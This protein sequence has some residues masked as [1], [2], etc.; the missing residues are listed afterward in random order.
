[1]LLSSFIQSFVNLITKVLLRD[2]PEIGTTTANFFRGLI[3]IIISLIYF[4]FRDIDIIHDLK[5]NYNKTKLLFFRCFFGASSHIF[6]YES[7]KYMRISSSA[8][9]FSTYPIVASLIS[10]LYL[11]AKIS[12]FQIFTYVA[13]FFSVILIAKPAFIFPT[14]DKVEDTPFGIFLALISAILNGIG[15]LINKQIAFDFDVSLSTFGYGF[16]F[17]LDSMILG[18]S[19][20]NFLSG[21]NIFDYSFF[22]IFLL[23]IFY[24]YSLIYFVLAL[25]IGDPI[26]S[27][28]F[29]YFGIVLNILYNFF[30]FGG[31]ID[32]LDILGSGT[33]ITV[34]ILNNIMQ[35]K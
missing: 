11:R 7:N 27:L 12:S 2:Y 6:L 15:T 20:G 32:F 34:N 30:L 22:L 4:R 23:S 16:L 18:I 5:K 24:F 13:C 21:I 8:V 10:V 35:L 33:I 25:N 26:K 31:K 1:M 29:T 28:P 19:A 3:M 17:C 9:I 14:N